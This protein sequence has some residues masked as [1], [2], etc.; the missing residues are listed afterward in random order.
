MPKPY[1]VELGQ[2]RPGDLFSFNGSRAYIMNAMHDLGA[3]MIQFRY[4]STKRWRSYTSIYHESKPVWVAV[5]RWY[6]AE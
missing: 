3:G 4:S 1:V 2:L 5:G 6:R